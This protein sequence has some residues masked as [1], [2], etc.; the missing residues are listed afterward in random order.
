M[1]N[2]QMFAFVYLPI[3]VVV[4]AGLFTLAT[5]RLIAWCDP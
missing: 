2:A 3:R 5:M 1:T 4:F